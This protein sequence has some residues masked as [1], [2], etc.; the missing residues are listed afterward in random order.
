MLPRTGS[1]VL[2]QIVQI[3][4]DQRWQLYHRLQE[5]NIP[6][7]RLENGSLQVE[8]DNTIALILLNSTV[9]QCTASRLSLIDWLKRC[10]Q[11]K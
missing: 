7:S 2:R 11:A 5:L 4:Y 9:I 1:N 3:P 8:I 6:C 10:W